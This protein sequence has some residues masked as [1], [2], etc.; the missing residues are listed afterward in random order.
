MINQQ[1]DVSLFQTNDD[2]D[3]EVVGGVVT[4]DGGLAT[5]A[6][7][8]LFG[9]N[10]D[11]DGVTDEGEW[12]GNVGEVEPARKYRSETQFLLKSIPAVSGNLLLIEAAA[13][14]DLAWF[15]SENVAVS[16]EVFAALVG[17]NRVEITVNINGDNT[18][19]FTE[20]WGAN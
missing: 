20:N 9:G 2:G 18:V 4:M 8:S 7:L 3:I 13:T 10:Q 19:K 17:I 11:D 15:I 1:G 12:W 6:Y 5:A 16:V 14:R